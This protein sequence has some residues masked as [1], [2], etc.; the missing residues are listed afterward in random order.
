MTNNQ[1]RL[2]YLV[3]NQTKMLRLRRLLSKGAKAIHPLASKEVR[4][5]LT[6]RDKATIANI[7][8]VC[9]GQAMQLSQER[10]AN[11]EAEIEGENYEQRQWENDL[12]RL[13]TL[14]AN[15]MRFLE[16]LARREIRV[17]ITIEHFA[18]LANRA[19]VANTAAHELAEDIWANIQKEIDELQ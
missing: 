15:G 9:Q 13:S 8:W 5:Q 10:T 17:R 1:A 3:A 6:I 18:T 14:L 16:P 12:Q 11:K 4:A 2:S 19:M 7:A